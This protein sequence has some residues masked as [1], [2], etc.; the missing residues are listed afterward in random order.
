MLL[1]YAKRRKA[2]KYNRRKGYEIQLVKKMER[3]VGVENNG[4]IDLNTVEAVALWQQRN[5]L[6]VDGKIGPKTL[7]AMEKSFPKKPD[8]PPVLDFMVEPDSDLEPVVLDRIENG[9]KALRRKSKDNNQKYQSTPRVASSVNGIT[10]HQMAFS[11]GNQIGKYDKVTA[12][13]I[14]TP[15][16]AIAQLHDITASLW[17]SNH[18]NRFTVA[19]EF[20]GNFRNSKGL[21]GGRFS[22]NYLTPR[23]VT[24]GRH[25]LKH[26]RDVHGIK[27]VYAHIQ[28]RGADRANC[29]GPEIWKSIAAWAM[30]PG[31]LG[32][33]DTTAETY[34]PGWPI[35]KKWL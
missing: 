1:T 13:Y 24:A 16:G 27:K 30:S 26:V 10:L 33:E 7:A 17:S 11:R 6:D 15:G 18:L 29:C 9:R 4:I 14:V 32:F 25:L 21:W 20:A 8:E 3:L 28:G 22:P 2:V 19:V 34:G 23:Q 5:G 31:G 12:H 35:P